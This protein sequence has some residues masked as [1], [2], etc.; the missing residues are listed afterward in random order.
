MPAEDD[1]SSEYQAAS[2]LADMIREAWPGLARRADARFTILVN[3]QCYGEEVE[4][5]DIILLIELPHSIVIDDGSGRGLRRMCATIEVKGHPRVEFRGGDVIVSY[6]RRDHNATAQSLKQRY[7]LKN[8]V[9]RHGGSAP[10]LTNMLWLRGIS[11]R[12]RPSNMSNV[13]CGDTSWGVFV[14]RML[15]SAKVRPSRTHDAGNVATVFDLMARSIEATPLDRKRIDR[16]ATAQTRPLE[17]FDALGRELVLLRGRGGT[18]K[19][20]QLLSLATALSVDRAQRVLIL[21]YN[22]AL[23]ADLRRL[24]ALMGARLGDEAGV[25]VR[26]VQ[27]FAYALLRA[28]GLIA[29]D[30]LQRTFL[31]KYESHIADLLEILQDES[32]R[33]EMLAAHEATG[34][35]FNWDYVLLDEGQDWPVGERDFLVSLYGRNRLVVA[36]GIEQ[37]VRGHSPTRWRTGPTDVV[38]E[39][40]TCLRM[41]SGLVQFANG[42]AQAAELGGYKLKPT[43]DMVGGSVSVFVGP[44]SEHRDEIFSAVRRHCSGGNKPVDQLVCV[45]GAWVDRGPTGKRTSSILPAVRAHN[46]EVWDGVGADLRV[47][48]PESVE[49]LRIVQYNSCRGLEGWSVCCLGL[50]EFFDQERTAALREGRGEADLLL[51][52]PEQLATDHAYRWLMIPFTR[53][54]DSLIIHVSDPAHSIVEPLRKAADQAGD[55][56]SWFESSLP[57]R[58]PPAVDAAP[59]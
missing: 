11:E 54:I 45:P 21:T 29:E 34:H 6:D 48:Y 32:A 57:V 30:E 40:K 59:F 37:M 22:R 23:V 35:D 52:E 43:R 39:Y 51:S 31:E 42:F 58:V 47:S 49:Q 26:T 2:S 15:D 4:D 44:W 46:F 36:D 33:A 53:P 8:Y 25:D 12:H 56:A 24:F 3:R 55:V 16:I 14:A 18:G 7:S 13:V 10:F 28:S 1:G 50:D 17:E 9:E 5:V 27:S 38:K 19:T 20:F 41:K